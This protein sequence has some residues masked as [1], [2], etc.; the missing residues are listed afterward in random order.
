VDQLWLWVSFNASV[1]AM[2]AVGLGVFHRSAHKV[3]V[4][5]AAAWSAVWV[6]LAL[7]FNGGIYY[8]WWLRGDSWLGDDKLCSLSF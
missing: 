5:E 3:S 6:A 1:L 2:L 4:K 8:C 7:S